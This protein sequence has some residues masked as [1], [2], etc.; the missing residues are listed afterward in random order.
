MLTLAMVEMWERFS[1]Y[2]MVSLLVLFLIA[3]QNGPWPPGPGQGFTDADSAALFGCY[4][5]LILATPLAG[6]WIGDRLIG[7]RRAFVIGAIFIAVG[8]FVLLI[9]TVIVF[10]AGLIVIALGTGLLKPNISTVLGSLYS[11]GDPRRDSGFSIFYLGINVGAFTAPLICGWIAVTVSWQWAFSVA[12]F[13]MLI[14]LLQYAFGRHRLGQNGISVPRPASLEQRH[15][16]TLVSVLGLLAIMGLFYATTTIFGFTASVISA[17]V[18]G[19]VTAIALFAFWFLLRRMPATPTVHRHVKAFALIFITSVVYFALSSQAGSTITEFTQESVDRTIGSFTIPTSWLMS[20]NPILVIMFAPIFAVLWA[21]LANHAPTTPTKMTVSLIGVGLSFL[22][23]AI[24]AL[25]VTNGHS[26]ALV[27]I[28][29][30]FVVLTWAELLIVPIAL[31][32]TTKLAPPGL[33]G[34][35]LG[36][37][38]LAAAVG[39]AVGGQIARFSEVLGYGN[40]FFVAGF[41]V[42]MIGAGFL[43]IRKRW[44]ALLAPMR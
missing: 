1:F 29:M 11:E 15:R 12:G 41:T 10:W 33:T 14:G 4:S 34:Q 7:P 16:A 38:Y 42:V 6:G 17:L 18:T 2:G 40:Y 31:S 3:P 44:S 5:A 22:I 20:L 24:P 25:S 19:V 28:V 32:T 43:L 13:G 21:R 9:P 26:T 35:L 27:W 39:G 36:L 37:W 30:G 23:V 8:H